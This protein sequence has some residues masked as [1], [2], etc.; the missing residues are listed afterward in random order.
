[1]NTTR[2]CDDFACLCDGQHPSLDSGFSSSGFLSA[3]WASAQ[4]TAS[5]E[6]MGCV[7]PC[8]IQLLQVTRHL[9]DIDEKFR[10]FRELFQH[11]GGLL[12]GPVEARLADLLQT[13]SSFLSKYPALNSHTIQPSTASLI[14]SMNNLHSQLKGTESKRYSEIFRSLDALEISIGN[15]YVSKKVFIVLLTRPLNVLILCLQE[16]QAVFPLDTSQAETCLAE[17]IEQVLFTQKAVDLLNDDANDNG[18]GV[19]DSE[20]EKLQIYEN[21]SKCDIDVEAGDPANMSVEEADEMLIK[22]DGGVEAA[23]EYAKMWCKYVKELL[24][25]VDKR[26]TYVSQPCPNPSDSSLVYPK[27][28]QFLHQDIMGHFVKGLAEIQKS[29]GKKPSAV[30]EEREAFFLAPH[31]KPI[32]HLRDPPVPSWPKSPNRVL[33]CFLF[34]EVEVAKNILKITEASKSFLFSQN[35]MPLQTLYTKVMEHHINVGNLASKTAGVLH[36]KQ[37]YEPLWAKKNEIEKWRKEF[38][39]QWQKEQKRMNDSLSSMRKSRLHYLQRCEDL[40][41]AKVL[42]AKAEEEFQAAAGSGNKQLEKRRRYREEAQLKALDKQLAPE[43]N[44]QNI[45]QAEG[46]SETGKKIS[47]TDLRV[48]MEKEKTAWLQLKTHDLLQ[49]LR[50]KLP[51]DLRVILEKDILADHLKEV[52]ESEITYKGCVCDANTRRQGLEKVRERIVSHIRKLVYQGDEVLTRVT[53]RMLKLQHEQAEQI[54][55]EYQNLIEFCT[56]YKSGEKYLEFI[57]N[58]QKRE[59]PMEVYKFDEFVPSGQRSPSY[60]RRKNAALYTRIPA[61]AADLSSSSEEVPGKQS[62]SSSEQIVSKSFYSDTESLGG[63]IECQSLD[64]LTSS[65]GHKKLLK[66]PSTGTVSSEECEDKDLISAYDNDLNDASENDLFLGQFKDIILSSAAR[67]HRLRKLRHRSKCRE[68][69]TFVDNGLECEECL[70]TCH[71]KCLESLLINCGHQKLPARVSL[72][73][74]DFLQVPRDFPEEVPFIVVKCTSEIESRALGVQGIYRISG[75]KVRMERLC[76]AFENGRRLVE[77]SNHSPHDITGI[78]KHFLKELT[79]PVLP[80]KLYDEFMA[81]SRS[82]QRTEDRKGDGSETWADSIKTAKDLLSKLPATNYNTL[83]HLIA[84]LYRVA[85]RYKENKM[86]PSNLGIIFGPTLIRPPASSYVSMSC[87]VE[88][89]Y[90]SQMVEFL[91]LNYERIFGIDDLPSAGL[92]ERDN[93]LK[94]TNTNEI[95][96][97]SEKDVKKLLPNL[98]LDL[99][100]D[101]DD[102]DNDDDGGVVAEV[103]S[104]TE[105]TEKHNMEQ[106][107]CT[108]TRDTVELNSRNCAKQKDSL[109]DPDTMLS[110]HP[111]GRFSRMP[112]KHARTMIPRVSTLPLL[113]TALSNSEAVS[114]LLEPGTSSRSSSPDTRGKC[115][116]FEITPETARIVSKLHPVNDNQDGCPNELETLLQ[117]NSLDAPEGSNT[118]A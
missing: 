48:M 17:R 39:D 111:R 58:L 84:H 44:M 19:S 37:Y 52:Q 104:S 45:Q 113:V 4:M 73:G 90:Q 65:P 27:T 81:L 51:W 35:Y 87:L 5:E 42:S 40:E 55:I 117:G 103:F 95:L 88:S 118:D 18:I 21:F 75:A 54:P 59:L 61:S 23:L 67:T 49:T 3:V 89:G 57:Q 15:A 56:P 101:E 46:K 41:K 50:S 109:L 53:L 86:S 100:L 96:S 24:I 70:M 63:S 32:V 85:E 78:L 2:G 25:W 47:A 22:C 114:G 14:T 1:M 76:Q 115:K 62:S 112:V 77:L 94:E 38:K 116:H 64:S 107:P 108:V 28:P 93:S 80:Y 69:E 102:D 31:P 10:H 82:L 74:I 106:T 72:F 99:E 8:P 43:Q 6:G 71:K 13:I 98:D 68:C 105:A 60:P 110:P 79:S 12:S 30:V 83:R 66:A 7:K 97:N 36:R 20:P 33:T 9:R 34:T 11:N 92:C 29:I 16:N 91:I 26:L